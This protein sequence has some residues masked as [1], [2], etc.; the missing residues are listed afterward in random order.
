MSAQSDGAVGYYGRP[1]IKQPVWTWEIPL[2]FVTGGMSGASAGLAFAAE[3]T[4]NRPLA[5]RAQ[6]TAFG[7]IAVSPAL[8]IS[9][10]GRPARFYNMLRLFKL[11]SPMSVG[12]WLLSA[13]GAATG[14]AT[15][16]LLS[17]RLP[18]VT[19][20]AQAVAALLGMPLTT[21]T[22]VLIADTAVPLWHEGRRELPFVFG[23]SSAAGAGALATL[24]TPPARSGP[25]RAL[26]IAGSVIE[27]TAS[28][29]MQRRL[30]ELAR[31]LSTGRAGRL[32]TV[33]KSLV[34]AGATL[35]AA[36]SVRGVIRGAG[37][38][39]LGRAGAG[40]VLAGETLERYAIFRAGFQS[41]ADP[42]YTVGPQR[43]RRDGAGRLDPSA[44]QPS[45]G[46]GA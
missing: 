35:V 28:I 3:L 29:L 43:R 24:L 2:Y 12:S 37:R 7:L 39:A 4:G 36:D 14:A 34:C 19:R 1:V 26:A 6:L 23:G 18:R 10:L 27:G 31:P 16:G 38:G 46:G 17:G 13:N 32:S 33:A 15:L 42:A 25:A 9:D 20:G 8:L 40:M 22:A 5:R 41:A 21:Y 45:A 30:G 44:A 11:S